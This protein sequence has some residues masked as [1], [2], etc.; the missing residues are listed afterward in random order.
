MLEAHCDL[1]ALVYSEAD[2][3]DRVLLNF[4]NDLKRDGYKPVGLVQH[5]HCQGDGSDLSALLIHSGETISLVQ[6]LG[7][8]SSGCRLDVDQLLAAGSRIVTSIDQDADLVVVNRF[9]RLEQEGKGLSFLIEL[10][11]NASVPAVIAVP[12]HRLQEWLQY[13]AGMSARLS[14]DQAALRQ[15]W[16]SLSSPDRSR[17]HRSQADALP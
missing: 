16:L 1:A 10:A 5:G 7:A 6:N 12:S 2:D 17:T 3:P 13:S 8:C 11:M 14:C 9:G 4:C 15:W